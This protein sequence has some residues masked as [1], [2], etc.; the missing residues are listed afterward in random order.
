MKTKD[1]SLVQVKTG[2][3]PNTQEKGEASLLMHKVFRWFSQNPTA[4]RHSIF[5]LIGIVVVVVV[6]L[7]VYA[8]ARHNHSDKLHEALEKY[9]LI[10]ILPRGEARQAQMKEFGLS[11]KDI[12][13]Q[14]ISTVESA[15]ACLS[16]GNALLEAREF[17]AAAKLFGKAASAYSSQPMISIAQFMQAQA[18]ESNR[19]FDKALALYKGLEKNFTLAKKP[20]MS[21][22]HQARM[23]YY[24]GRYDEAEEKF[25]KLSR[26]NEGKEF[27]APS[28]NY[29]SL[30]NAERA[31]KSTAPQNENLKK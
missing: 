16:G 14:T 12:C 10:K 3:S 1:S 2:S 18:Y 4:V 17:A 22:F 25:A 31:A 9:E 6:I 27:A 21:T 19:E 8:A 15:A 30:L 20:E 26:E 23:L 7:F 29:I 13:E 11:L 5:T 24:L 28:R